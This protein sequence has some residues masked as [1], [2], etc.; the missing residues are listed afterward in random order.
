MTTVAILL[1][2]F[3]VAS[4]QCKLGSKGS[5]SQMIAYAYHDCMHCLHPCCATAVDAT[6]ASAS[7]LQLVVVVA[8]DV[9]AALEE[10]CVPQVSSTL[11]VRQ[12]CDPCMTPSLST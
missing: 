8:L 4:A 1:G 7:C 6:S 12:G 9:A 5:V 11:L 3:A 2:I 10:V